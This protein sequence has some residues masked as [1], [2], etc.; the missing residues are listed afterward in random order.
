MPTV[1]KYF[2]IIAAAVGITLSVFYL[3]HKL[4]GVQSG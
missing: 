4:I 3:M 2:G 1:F